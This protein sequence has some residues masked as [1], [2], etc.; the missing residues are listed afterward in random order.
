MPSIIARRAIMIRA[1][2]WISFRRAGPS[3]GARD[4]R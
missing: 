3:A 4:P 1:A 2:I